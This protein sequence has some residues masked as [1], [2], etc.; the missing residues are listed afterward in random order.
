MN[1]KDLLKS[2]TKRVLP[3][4]LDNQQ[5]TSDNLD[6]KDAC[7]KLITYKVL[8]ALYEISQEADN[9]DKL[10][11]RDCINIMKSTPE[12]LA[13]AEPVV[14]YTMED[15]ISKDGFNFGATG[16]YLIEENEPG[17]ENG[18][19]KAVYLFSEEQGEFLY[20]FFF[21]N[22]EVVF[23][24]RQLSAG[25]AC[26]WKEYLAEIQEDKTLWDQIKAA[27]HDGFRR[28]DFKVGWLAEDLEEV[29]FLHQPL[30]KHREE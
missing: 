5:V 1:K 20:D 30:N 29:Q 16:G 22:A 19:L 7:I 4:V 11:W 9:D 27:V 13:A 6:Y 15:F 21:L 12:L 8:R 25:K 28:M 24:Y 26:S 2:M 18:I 10:T 3:A 17:E 14:L 23:Y